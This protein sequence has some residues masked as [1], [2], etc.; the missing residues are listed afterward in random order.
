MPRV[1]SLPTALSATR[2]AGSSRRPGALS[3]RHYGGRTGAPSRRVP[4][5]ETATRGRE[6]RLVERDTRQ[7]GAQFRARFAKEQRRRAGHAVR[8]PL[9]VD[10][11]DRFLD[12]GRILAVEQS[13][14]VHL[15][16]A[17]GG[18]LDET[19]VQ[20]AC[21]LGAL[22]RIDDLHE[23]E[24]AVLLGSRDRRLPAG[25]RVRTYEGERP[26]LD[27]ELPGADELRD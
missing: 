23:I 22:V 14:Y 24:R 19:L 15:R 11:A 26:R 21:V 1:A 25:N 13:P 10:P 20:P 5:A 27:L 7:D 3:S 17:R 8:V 4:L 6:L 16:D 9:R 12:G 18:M 2:S